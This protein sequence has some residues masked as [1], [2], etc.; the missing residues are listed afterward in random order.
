MT[1]LFADGVRAIRDLYFIVFGI[2]G[3]SLASLAAQTTIRGGIDVERGIKV[4]AD[5]IYGPALYTAHRLEKSPAQHPLVGVG[6]GMTEYLERS[7]PIA[8]WPIRG[9]SR[10]SASWAR[11]SS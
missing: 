7:D 11:S 10:A 8:T 9:L 4:S 3:M 2:A 5:E 6:D 1:P